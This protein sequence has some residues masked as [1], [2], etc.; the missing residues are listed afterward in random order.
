MRHASQEIHVEDLQNI[1][2]QFGGSGPNLQGFI[3]EI[4][5]KQ[6]EEGICNFSLPILNIFPRWKWRS[7]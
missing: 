1:I 7:N 2:Q 6:A 3:D 5:K 4:L